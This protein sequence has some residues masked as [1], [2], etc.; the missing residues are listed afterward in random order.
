MV[1][2]EPTALDVYFASAV[3]QHDQTNGWALENTPQH[4][5]LSRMLSAPD[6]G[7]GYLARLFGLW[8]VRYAIVFGADAQAQEARNALTAAGFALKGTASEFEL[9]ALDQRPSPLQSLPAKQML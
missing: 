4:I 1:Y 7:P 6:W 3:G 2:P 5:A 9:W 8:D